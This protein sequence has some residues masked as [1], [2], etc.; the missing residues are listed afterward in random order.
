LSG[1]SRSSQ[2][3]PPLASNSTTFSRLKSIW[4]LPR[5]WTTTQ[6]L[7]ALRCEDGA[8]ASGFSPHECRLAGVARRRVLSHHP[9]VLLTP[10][11]AAGRKLSSDRWTGR[12]RALAQRRRQAPED[13]GSGIPSVESQDGPL[14]GA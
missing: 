13:V 2:K 10:R 7:G 4:A 5:S 9:I 1:S 11:Y 14:T 8:S 12:R 6:V 3:K